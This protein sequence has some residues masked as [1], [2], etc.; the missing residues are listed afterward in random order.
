MKKNNLRVSFFILTLISILYSYELHAQK[1]APIPMGTAEI[2]G[3]IEDSWDVCPETEINVSCQTEIPTVSGWWKVMYDADHLYLVVNVEDEGNHFPGWEAGGSKT[4][5]DIPVFFFDWNKHPKDGLGPSTPYS[6]HYMFAD[7]FEK[8]MYDKVITKEPS[9]AD[10]Y[11]GGTYCYTLNGEGYVYEM[12]IPFYNFYDK[13]RVRIDKNIAEAKM[14]FGFDVMIVDQDE[15][16]T[17][18]PAAIAWNSNNKD[19]RINM[20]SAGIAQFKICDCAVDFNLSESFIEIKDSAIVDVKTS[21]YSWRVSPSQSWVK[22]IPPEG[23]SDCRVTIYADPLP[24]DTTRI[25]EIRFNIKRAD[26]DTYYPGKSVFVIQGKSTNN[27]SL[28]LK[29]IRLYPNP[30]HDYFRIEGITGKAELHVYDLYGR[31]VLKKEVGNK[32]E[33]NTST[34]SRGIYTVK[35]LSGDGVMNKKIMKE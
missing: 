12:S 11:P 23:N 8:G 9:E 2:D 21:T 33:I 5:Y 31:Q 6:G 17:T 30:V 3:F 18:A 1:V 10:S 34:L 24:G 16:M 29:S 26:S 13:H 15:G 20:D 7:G 35:I 27:K 32:E 28:A 25:A 4:D 22:V 14:N 19:L